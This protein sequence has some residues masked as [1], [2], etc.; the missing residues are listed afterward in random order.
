MHLLSLEVDSVNLT[1]T[2]H[3]EV[4]VKIR[5]LGIGETGRDDVE[6]VVEVENVIVESEITAEKRGEET[7]RVSKDCLER[8]VPFAPPTLLLSSVLL[9][10]PRSISPTTKREESETREVDE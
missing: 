4:S 3:S 7:Q 6:G 9:D 1:T 2:T 10:L 8:G 5:D